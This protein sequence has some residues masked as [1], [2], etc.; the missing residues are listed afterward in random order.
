MKKALLFGLLLMFAFAIIPNAQAQDVSLS[1][2]EL[3]QLGVSAQDLTQ[4]KVV[5]DKAS[6]SAEALPGLT[7]TKV[8]FTNAGGNRFL[9]RID[10]ADNYPVDNS[11]VIFYINTDANE[12]T[13]RTNY[14]GI[15]LMLWVDNGGT[16]TS[17]YTPEGK[18][19]DGPPAFAIIKEKHLFVSIDIDLHQQDNAT[20]VPTRIIAQ[21]SQPLK[22]QSHTPFFELRG[23]PISSDA[24]LERVKPTFQNTN[25]V[26]T[27]GLH[28]LRR[29]Q[30]DAGNIWIPIT[31]AELSG[32]AIDYNVEYR[33]NSAILRSGKGSIKIAAPRAGRFYPSFVLYDET[34]D[35]AIGFFV[36]G[37]QRGMAVAKDADNNQKLFALNKAVDLQKG[38]VVEL[39]NLNQNGRFR[40]EGVLLL[41]ELFPQ[42]ANQYTFNYMAATRPWQ[43]PDRMRITFTTTWPARVKVLFGT[44]EKLGNEVEE[45]TIP[46]N[47]HRVYLQDLIEGEKYFYR[48]S[49]IDRDDKTVLSPI[50]TFV[51]NKPH[52][53]AAIAQTQTVPLQ[54][55]TL[56]KDASW[57]VN[58][59]VPFEQGAVFET[60]NIRLLSASNKPL[61]AQKKVLSRWHDGSIKWALMSFLAEP[62]QTKYQ[63][64]YG[65]KITDENH[66][67]L[68]TKSHD[69]ISINT[70][71]LQWKAARQASGAYAISLM[72]GG[73]ELLGDIQLVIS[74]QN[75]K[76]YTSDFKPDEIAIEQ[77]GAQYAVIVT[78]GS[79]VNPNDQNTLFRYEARW[80]F[81]NNSPV[82]RVQVTLINDNTK[83]TFTHLQNAVLRFRLPADSGTVMLANE[84]NFDV[85][86]DAAVRVLQTFDD[87]YQIESAQGEKSGNRFPGWMQWKNNSQQVALAV[88]NFWQLY[89]KA[90]SVKGNTL[91]VGLAP[92]VNAGFYEKFKGTVEEY[93]S[94]Y[95]L[96]DGTYKL[97]A[98][99]SFTTE[100]AL[101]VSGADGARLADYVNHQPVLIA[102]P[103]YYRITKAFGDIGI[104]NE[105][106]LIQ[107]YNAKTAS[108]FEHYINE[109]DTLHEYGLM[110]YGDWWGERGINWGNVEYDTQHAFILQFARSSDVSYLRAAEDAAIHNRD[111]DTVHAD[112]APPE[113]YFS[114][115]GGGYS[116]A[117]ATTG[118]A[119]SH[120]IGHVGGYF[121][122]SPVKGQGSPS[123]HFSSSHTWT[124]GHYEYYYIT[125]DVRSLHVAN[126]IADVYDTY[127]LTNYDFSNCRV[128]GWTLI[129]TMGAYNATNDPF[130]L[131]AAR[132]IVDRVLERQTPDGGWDR[133]LVPGH[134]TH[135]PRHHGN[136]GFMVGVLMSGLKYYAEATGDQRARDSI[137][138]A[139]H[140][141]INDMWIPEAKAF[142]YTSCPSS[143]IAPGLNLLIC[144]GVAY[145]WR[146]TKEPQLRHVTLAAVQNLIGRMDGRGKNISME[147][148]STPRQLFDVTEMLKIQDPVS[149][150]AQAKIPGAGEGGLVQFSAQAKTLKGTIQ[151]Y[152]WKFADG[153]T[154]EGQNV[155][156]NY[157]NGGNYRVEVTAIN[158][159]NEKATHTI[160]IN[161]P[162]PFLQEMNKATDVMIQAEDFTAQGG[163]G[164]AIEI[165]EGRVNALGKAITKWEANIGHWAEWKFTIPQ[166]GIYQIT[167]KYASGSPQAQRSVQIDEKYPNAALEKVLLPGTGGYSSG[168]DDWKFWKLLNSERKPLEVKLSKGVHTLR[169]ANISGGLALDYILVQKK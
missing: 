18:I 98:G 77:N 63:L 96:M 32:W 108:S 92:Q 168:S 56:P 127:A 71:A 22:S 54:L 94:V 75:N 4:L 164:N 166:D 1:S 124:E 157:P 8:L 158:S 47:N 141:M 26:F 66:A 29:M 12:K 10:F 2:E 81:T 152:L 131:N 135:T 65:A 70:S 53:P 25:V 150:T 59:G 52:Y 55:S 51:F 159:D 107:E 128:P 86:S 144:E 143:S 79:L 132:I 156:H 137:V 163:G 138:K 130:Y 114:I 72:R 17:F 153:T 42:K 91:D 140:F 24:K 103:E 5:T 155:S 7:I 30:N 21:T 133:Q 136:A 84:G 67:A 116:A 76:S 106:P 39:R 20:M 97:R 80:H 126:Q 69:S 110:N 142:R 105:F 122:Q 162:P 41:K 44:T 112:V 145:A 161:V 38:D 27:W 35:A 123:G 68:A 57:P 118:R 62:S 11:N 31:E 121:S 83:S 40:I 88:R 95:Y 149:V 43:Q 102:E 93:R 3:S 37:Q 19:I 85:N 167:L 45:S 28:D 34:P 64:Q 78:R 109:R 60:R 90:F 9:W 99:V 100:I 58:S 139:A 87:H 82:A 160:S 165:V 120:S 147:L 50:E 113:K 74:D 101:D 14:Q 16:R 46:L 115:G 134:C 119:W 61:H 125:G 169:I 154:G 117:A 15:D 73:K 146:Q 23:A 89:P 104:G 13:G 36:N 33:E 49:A 111:I 148:R 129:F 6:A 151:K 48:L